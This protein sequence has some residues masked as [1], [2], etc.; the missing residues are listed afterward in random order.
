MTVIPHY[1]KVKHVFIK[2]VTFVRR[3][4]YN[5]YERHFAIVTLLCKVRL[6]TVI[7]HD[8]EGKS[9]GTKD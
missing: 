1:D 7:P 5:I 4:L 2:V 6:M 9:S 8:D 3:Y